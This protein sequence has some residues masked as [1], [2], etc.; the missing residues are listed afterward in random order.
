MTSF[1]QK[2]KEKNVERKIINN[3]DTI[4]LSTLDAGHLKKQE[5]T[6]KNKQTNQEISFSA[7]KSVKRNMSIV[8]KNHSIYKLKTP[9]FCCFFFPQKYHSLNFRVDA[10]HPECT[11]FVIVGLGRARTARTGS[12]NYIVRAWATAKGR[13]KQTATIR[14]RSVYDIFYFFVVHAV[15][16][17]KPT[18]RGT[19][20]TTESMFI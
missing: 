19:D 10:K 8:P 15:H 1:Q 2:K 12:K 4:W 16:K 20:Y 13:V 3:I 9:L 18:H 11:T 14:H 5:K 6:R 7:K 17:E